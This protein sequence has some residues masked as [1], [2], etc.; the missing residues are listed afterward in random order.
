MR[1]DVSY[2]SPNPKE[3]I[4]YYLQQ[5]VLELSTAKCTRIQRYICLCHIS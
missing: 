5:W 2:T 3:N 1:L 4:P